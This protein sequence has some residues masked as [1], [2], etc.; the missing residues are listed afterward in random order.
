[1]KPRPTGLSIEYAST[2]VAA[3]LAKRPNE[4]LWAQLRST[5][6]LVAL[7]DALRQT[8]C[9]AY[10]SGIAA[11]DPLPDI[12]FAFRQHL[13]AQIAELTAIAPDDWQSAVAFTGWLIELPA[14]AHLA[15]TE[16]VP[17]WISRDPVLGEYAQSEPGTRHRALTTDIPGA[18]LTRAGGLPGATRLHPLVAAW[19]H[20]WI[21]RWPPAPD[22]HRTSL[23]DLVAAVKRHLIAFRS[24][25]PA[26]S[27]T[28]R[29]QLSDRMAAAL[30]RASA[31]PAAL[32]AWLV[33][34]ALDL[35][36]LRGLAIE[37]AAF[38]E[39]PR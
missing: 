15:G 20:Q 33:V 5:R 25:D 30:R 13:R 37:R 34:L 22:E 8:D 35:E 19:E 4:R 12:E 21:G 6:S 32:F 9:A 1:M 7:L 39:P 27:E 28:L 36:R 38:A 26:D 11:G 10:V 24:A 14:L 3:R 2:R 29:A 31:Q 18:L 17:A 16:A 23:L